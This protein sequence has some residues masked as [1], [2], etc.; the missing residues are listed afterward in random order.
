MAVGVTSTIKILA[1]LLVIGICAGFI[2]DYSQTKSNLQAK[3]AEIMIMSDK[4][5]AQNDAIAGLKLDVEA[6]KN[7][8]PQIIEK[9]VTKYQNIEVKDE[10]CEAKLEAIHEAQKLF[11]QSIN[12]NSKKV[13]VKD[14]Q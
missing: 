1:L 5:K 9:I 12:K 8:K 4:I 3:K 6:Y 2:Y 14:R 11:Y 13:E 7:K 10:T